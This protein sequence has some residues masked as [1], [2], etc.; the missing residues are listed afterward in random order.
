MFQWMA[1]R[2]DDDDDDSG[3]WGGKIRKM[4]KENYSY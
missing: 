3:I 4:L 1:I 2:D